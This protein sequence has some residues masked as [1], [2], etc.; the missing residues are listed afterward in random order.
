[1]PK[2]RGTFV[3]LCGYVKDGVYAIQKPI[4]LKGLEQNPLMESAN[5]SEENKGINGEECRG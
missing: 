3:A 2:V 5:L 4:V 1:M